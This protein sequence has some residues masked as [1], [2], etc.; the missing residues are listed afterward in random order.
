MWHPAHSGV[1][2]RDRLV[3]VCLAF[4]RDRA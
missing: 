1:N 4:R 2:A 3:I